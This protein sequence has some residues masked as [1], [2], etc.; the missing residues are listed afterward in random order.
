MECW[1]HK[2]M[3]KVRDE[4]TQGVQDMWDNVTEKDLLRAVC[5]R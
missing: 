4:V 2:D 3:H 1:V 5:G